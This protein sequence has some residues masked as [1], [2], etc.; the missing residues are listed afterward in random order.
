MY[1]QWLKVCALSRALN[2][3]I[4]V[5]RNL[6]MKAE[7]KIFELEVLLV[8]KDE[9][10]KSVVTELERSQKSLRFL[11]N[12]SSKLDHLITTGKSF[13]DYGGI[14]YKGE[15]Y[16]SKTVFV[17]SG[18]LDDSLNVYVK[19]YDVKFVATKQSIATGK[20]V[21]NIRQKCKNKVFIPVCH[22]CGVKGH[23]RSRCYTLMNFLENHHDKSIYSMYFQKPTIRPKI[24]LNDNSRKMWVKKSELKFLFLIHAYEP[25]VLMLGS[26]T[27]VVLSI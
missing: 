2:D 1:K 8:E 20:S 13:S 15:S 9:N 18:L 16:G 4:Q 7:G 11:N 21:S 23:I 22:F 27:V 3:E 26:L 14:E 12:G 25:L 5:L 24:K 19:K 17:K 6:N 10:L